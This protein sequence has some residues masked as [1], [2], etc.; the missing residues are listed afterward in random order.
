MSARRF[1]GGRLVHLRNALGVTQ[2]EVARRAGIHEAQLSRIEGEKQVPRATL[3]GPLAA[4]LRCD[5]SDFFESPDGEK[6][7][8]DDEESDLLAAAHELD[9]AGLYELA[10]RL[11][12]RAREIARRLEMSA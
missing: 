10:D 6:S 1:R 7:A 11:R 4:A 2:A 3:L 5:V 9:R 12:R 8:D